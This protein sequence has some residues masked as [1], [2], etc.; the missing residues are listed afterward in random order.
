MGLSQS[1]MGQALKLRPTEYLAPPITSL[2]DP[3]LN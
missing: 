3:A 1:N 2:K